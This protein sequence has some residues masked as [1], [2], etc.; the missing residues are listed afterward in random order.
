[1]TSNPT[2]LVHIAD[3]AFADRGHGGPES[4]RQLEDFRRKSAQIDFWERA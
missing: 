1:M 3:R 2:P 4:A